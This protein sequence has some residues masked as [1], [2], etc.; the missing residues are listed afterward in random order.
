MRQAAS[1]DAS[2][3]SARHCPN[4][5][6]TSTTCPDPRHHVGPDTS[7]P[8]TGSEVL[9]S[10]RPGGCGQI[11]RR[12]TDLHRPQS[13]HWTVRHR[14]SGVRLKPFGGSEESRSGGRRFRRVKKH[15]HAQA[16]GVSRTPPPPA[17][18]AI[19]RQ[20]GRWRWAAQEAVA[21][22]VARQ[23]GRAFPGDV[24]TQVVNPS[25]PGSSHA[26]GSDCS[27]VKKHACLVFSQGTRSLSRSRRG[28]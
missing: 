2:A 4:V 1:A 18:A 26:T 13:G 16:T 21:R 20:R 9:T 12:R 28:G 23:R 10:V 24:T 27:V 5:R 6:S 19:S 11:I 22:A 8:S 17:P 25:E 14:P 15:L 7:E 3:S